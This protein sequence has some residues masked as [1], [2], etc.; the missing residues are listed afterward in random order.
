MIRTEV[1][2]KYLV[3]KRGRK[4]FVEIRRSSDGK[5]FVVIEKSLKHVF[6]KNDEEMV[7]EQDIKD[8]EE[9]EY[10]KLPE[11]VRRVLSQLTRF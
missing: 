9:I 4:I 6:M 5:M 3:N 1:E 2:K 7:W 8:A 11:E 10:E